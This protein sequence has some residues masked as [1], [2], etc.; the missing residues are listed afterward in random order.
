MTE[1]RL[2]KDTLSLIYMTILSVA[3]LVY[4]FTT[5]PSPTQQR[6]IKL[7]HERVS[8]LGQ[9]NYTI[10]DYY[11]NH[12]QLP[13]A[14][15]DL[16]G[17]SYSTGTPLVTKDPETNKPYEYIVTSETSYKL[18]ATFAT[19]SLKEDRYTYD[20]SN[21]TYSSFSDQFRHGKGYQCF[22][23]TVPPRA[24]APIGGGNGNSGR[25][26]APIQDLPKSAPYQEN[27]GSKGQIRTM[28]YQIDLA[29]PA[30]PP[31]H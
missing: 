1:K 8:D 12:Q 19:S 14:L 22:I 4:G 9:I 15:E 27:P 26:P 28:P 18:C 7:D 11:T 24:V 5:I 13:K 30:T 25:E 21:Y 23:K 2:N 3:A 17:N 20:D 6:E 10:S 29:K 16:P 31:A